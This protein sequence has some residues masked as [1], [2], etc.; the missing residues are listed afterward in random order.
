[1]TPTPPTTPP[2]TSSTPPTKAPSIYIATPAYGCQ[3]TL[4][5]LASVLKLQGECLKRGVQCMV[6][7]LGNESLISRCRCIMTARYLKS[8]ADFM[9]W[10][11]ADIA[12]SPGSILDRLLPFAMEHPD[13]IVT[14]VYAKKS[15]S[16]DRLTKNKLPVPPSG[17]QPEPLQARGLDY[18][19]NVSEDSEILPNGFA[20]VLDSAT[21]FMMVPRGVLEKMNE[22]YKDELYCVNDIPGSNEAI[23]D[24]IALYDTMICPETKR[25][26]S[27]DYA[28]VRRYQ[29]MGGELYVDIA[30]PLAHY[31]SRGYYG[32]IKTRFK[33]SLS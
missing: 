29:A 26:L 10:I 5:F 19:I 2:T 30:S 7:F 16:F 18:N 22:H 25:Y 3:V 23:P 13:A 4:S 33:V 32:D 27:E 6:D 20:K 11:D 12:F 8:G 31:G 17:T 15:Y 24:Y 1:M 9:M 21:G 28:F 14:G